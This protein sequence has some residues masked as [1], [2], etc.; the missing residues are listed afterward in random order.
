LFYWF[1]ALSMKVFSSTAEWAARMP[2]A[3]MA[4]LIVQIQFWMMRRLKGVESWRFSRPS[5]C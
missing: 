4:M 1:V 3:L 5:F 2:S